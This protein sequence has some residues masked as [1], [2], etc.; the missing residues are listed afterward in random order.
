MAQT[1]INVKMRQAYD[2]DANWATKNPVLLSGQMAVSSDKTGMYKIGNGTSTWS[3]LKY[4]K[5][6]SLDGL[7]AT[8]QELNTLEHVTGNIQT[9]LNNKAAS[10]HTHNYLPLAGGT[11]T[12]G[13]K[14]TLSS[15]Q[16]LLHASGSTDWAKIQYIINSSDDCELR[17]AIGDDI[18]SRFTWFGNNTKLM[19][20]QP[21]G[22]GTTINGADLSITGKLNAVAA[23]LSGT[24]SV[25]GTSLF[26]QKTTHNGGIDAT[27]AKLSGDLIIAR[28]TTSS[29]EYGSQNPKISFR[30]GDASQ[31]V[32]LIFN[33][34]DTMRKPYG[35]SIRGNKQSNDN[36]GAYLFVEGQVIAGNKL[37]S[38]GGLSVSGTSSFAS[39]TIH[40]GG[41]QLP[42]TGGSYIHGMTETKCIVGTAYSSSVGNTYHPIIRQNTALGNVFNI[43]GITQ[44][45][46][47]DY[48]GIYVFKNGRT[49]NGTDYST[50][51]NAITGLLKHSSDLEIAGNSTFSKQTVHNGGLVSTTGVFSA[52]LTANKDVEIKENLYMTGS[53]K[54]ICTSNNYGIKGYSSDKSK[55]FYIAYIDTSNRLTVGYNN[56]TPIYLNC[57]TKVNR[58]APS[59]SKSTGAL[60]VVGGLGVGDRVSANEVMVG[61]HMV[62]KYD[63]ANACVNF[64]FV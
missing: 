44:S 7:T 58:P 17:F 38:N 5:A 31:N 19:T 29:V 9:Q 28:E 55:A 32:D 42:N 57:D 45:A 27:T 60:T 48:F 8:I 1:T 47:A 18:S 24:L 49:D 16:D 36:G 4:N 26:S 64:T 51:I 11:M 20:L 12:G 56:E 3:Q 34:H 23:N 13:L 52:K 10:T 41:L 14:W 25:T 37:S 62:L 59:T 61:D 54:V 43:G 33:D 6:A 21:T 40:S 22:S 35:L 15:S 53:G 50:T 30:N 39:Q 46:S 63:S 2:T